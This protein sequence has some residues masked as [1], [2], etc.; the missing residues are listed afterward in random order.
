[1]KLLLL[2][3]SGHSADEVAGLLDATSSVLVDIRLAA[4]SRL[5]AYNKGALSQAL[6]TRY[7]HVPELG[8]LNYRTG[9]SIQIA[10]I[11]QGAAR[12]EQIGHGSL[13]L[14]CAC[15]DAISCHRTVVGSELRAA[16][17]WPSQEIGRI[18]DFLAERA[19]RQPELGL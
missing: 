3:Y 18:A 16:R 17:G 12:L 9:G 6:G 13:V 7:V 10:D 5:Q 11:Q 19:T 2:G 8:N 15:R 1:M 14:M 4:R